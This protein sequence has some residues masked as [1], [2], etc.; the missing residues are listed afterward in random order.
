[1]NFKKMRNW[2]IALAAFVSVAPA[3]N[4]LVRSAGPVLFRDGD[5]RTLHGWST[6]A[7]QEPQ[8]TR[9][10]GPCAFTVKTSDGKVYASN[11]AADRELLNLLDDLVK[12]GREKAELEKKQGEER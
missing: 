12:A 8:V 2:A 3:S 10:F 7:G 5:I 11:C 4:G 1:M 6:I 9:G